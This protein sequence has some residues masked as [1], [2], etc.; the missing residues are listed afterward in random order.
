MGLKNIQLPKK[1]GAKSKP[2]LEPMTVSLNLILN[3]LAK[4]EVNNQDKVLAEIRCS[5][6]ERQSKDSAYIR[7]GRIRD[8]QPQRG[9]QC[10]SYSQ[11]Q[12]TNPCELMW[13]N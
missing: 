10:W 6:T 8:L 9:L 3:Q 12:D 13:D 1:I 2:W 11:C 7:Q 4:G 5:R